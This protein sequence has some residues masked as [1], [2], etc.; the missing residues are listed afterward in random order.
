MRRRPARSRCC[1]S[2]HSSLKASSAASS[3][4]SASGCRSRRQPAADRSSTSTPRMS[5]RHWVPVCTSCLRPA[6]AARSDGSSSS[7]ATPDPTAARHGPMRITLPSGTPAELARPSSEGNAARPWAS[8]SRRTSSACAHCSTTCARDSPTNGRGRLRAGAVPRAWTSGPTSSPLRHRRDAGGRRPPARTSGMRPTPPA[9]NEWVMIGFCIGGMYALKAVGRSP[10][11]AAR[12]L[13]RDDPRARRLASARPGRAARR[14]D[15]AEPAGFW[16]SS[17]SGIRTR[18][19][20]TSPPSRPSGSSSPATQ[21][22]STASST[23][24]PTGPPGRRRRRRVAARPVTRL[25]V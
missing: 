25:E 20:A 16:R 17:A 2:G 10:V 23:T 7:D 13:L 9:A 22:P 24:R 4:R 5:C 12:E 18:R 8:S 19:P 21:R 3:R 15:A 11:R 1:S 14:P 6:A